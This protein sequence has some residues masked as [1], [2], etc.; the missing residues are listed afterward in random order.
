M[1][2]PPSPRPSARLRLSRRRTRGVVPSWL[3]ASGVLGALG[4]LCPSTASAD[5]GSLGDLTVGIAASA[6]IQPD[7]RGCTVGGSVRNFPGTDSCMLFTGGLEASFLWR[8]RIGAALGVWSVAGQASVATKP[9]PDAPDTPGF[10]DRVSVPLLLDVRPLSFLS[11]ASSRGY[12][13]SFLHG[14]RLGLGPSFELVR[15]SQQSSL[16]WGDRIG[17]RARASLGMHATF[18]VEAPLYAVPDEERGGLSLRLSVRLLYVPI[19]TLKSANGSE[20]FSQPI[21]LPP[22]DETAAD[23]FHGLGVRTQIFLGLV[24]YM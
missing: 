17:S 21:E 13:A 4:L 16:L 6:G 5:L 2:T 8:G 14:V 11:A 9:S 24:Y 19:V 7:E 1:S 18:D 20:V 23:R 3:R 12:L 10:P 15:T 22:G